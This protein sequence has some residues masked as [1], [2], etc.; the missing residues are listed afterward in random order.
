MSAQAKRKSG[1]AKKPAAAGKARAKRE[2]AL[3]ETVSLTR[4]RKPP[5]RLRAESLHRHEAGCKDGT[6]G[7]EIVLWRGPGGGLAVSFRFTSC[8]ETIA[9]ASRADDLEQAMR[10]VET[11]EPWKLIQPSQPMTEAPY[12]AEAAIAQLQEFHAREVARRIFESLA[13]EALADWLRPNQSQ[14]A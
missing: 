14:A 13:G 12:S 9:D 3:G 2:P 1:S 6:T 8:N 10:F 7:S 5:L 11:A 4:Y